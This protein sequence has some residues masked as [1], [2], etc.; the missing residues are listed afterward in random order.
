MKEDLAEHLYFCKSILSVIAD[1]DNKSI[2]AWEEGD[3]I[4]MA[5]EGRLRLEQALKLIQPSPEGHRAI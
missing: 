3:V 2:T 1:M 5:L 4:N